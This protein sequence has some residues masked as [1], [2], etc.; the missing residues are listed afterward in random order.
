MLVED[1][2]RT[3]RIRQ[4]LD[5]NKLEF[6]QVAAH[7]LRTP[8]TVMLGWLGVIRSDPA[9]GGSPRLQAV[10]DGLRQGIERLHAIVTTL[11]TSA[12]STA[13]RCGWRRCRCR[14]AAW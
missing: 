12:G 3:N 1:L 11:R 8:L 4:Q 7:E 2:R 6:I 13:T 5:R 9:V 10:L 14:S